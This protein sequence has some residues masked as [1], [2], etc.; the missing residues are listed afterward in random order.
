MPSLRLKIEVVGTGGVRRTSA[1]RSGS[2]SSSR[3]PVIA[4]YR[5]QLLLA[6]VSRAKGLPSEM[7]LRTHSGWRLAMTRA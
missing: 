5:R 4:S 3:S 2:I 7:M 6:L 1:S